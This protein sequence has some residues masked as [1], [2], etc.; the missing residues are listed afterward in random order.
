MSSSIVAASL[1]LAVTRFP[2]CFSTTGENTRKTAPANQLPARKLVSCR[3]LRC[4]ASD[5]CLDPGDPGF[6]VGNTSAQ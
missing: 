3:G 6:K 5:E 4:I 1:A 2:M